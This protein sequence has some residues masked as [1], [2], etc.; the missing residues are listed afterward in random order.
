VSQLPTPFHR[1]YFCPK[2]AEEAYTLLY[3]FFTPYA[4]WDHLCPFFDPLLPTSTMSDGTSSYK[5][6]TPPLMRTKSS[7]GGPLAMRA[8]ALIA[9]L[10]GDSEEERF[11]TWLWRHKGFDMAMT[12][13][14]TMM[15]TTTRRGRRRRTTTRWGGRQWRR[16]REPP[17]KWWSKND[18][19]SDG[20]DHA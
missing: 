12:P 3:I 16:G 6:T 4:L 17:A 20:E 10:I 14:R 18:P 15:A 7:I 1:H 5:R 13:Q 11:L 19:I 8:L 2:E 9:C